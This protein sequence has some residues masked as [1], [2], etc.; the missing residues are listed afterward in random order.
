MTSKTTIYAFQHLTILCH[1][2]MSKL[3]QQDT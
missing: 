2:L 3:A 1:G